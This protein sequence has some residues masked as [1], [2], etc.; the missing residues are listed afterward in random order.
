[1]HSW[2][3]H[4]TEANLWKRLK[5]VWKFR[6]PVLTAVCFYCPR[7]T[8]EN[9]ITSTEPK[10]MSKLLKARINF[11][12]LHAHHLLIIKRPKAPKAVRKPQSDTNLHFNSFAFLKF[13]AAFLFRSQTKNHLSEMES[14]FYWPAKRTRATL[15]LW[16]PYCL[17]YNRSEKD[18]DNVTKQLKIKHWENREDAVLLCTT[19]CWL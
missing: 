15:Y 3:I 2:F 8:E 12:E 4:D 9:R 1:M 5:T 19:Y 7:V 14:H 17:Q 11:T 18:T 10:K 13:F 16:V 6:L